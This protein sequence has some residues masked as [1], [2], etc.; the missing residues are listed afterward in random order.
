MLSHPARIVLYMSNEGRNIPNPPLPTPLEAWLAAI[1]L[2]AVEV[3][4]CPDP[5]CKVC[6]SGLPRAA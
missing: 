5:A 6:G 3:D 2:P 1:G 4:A